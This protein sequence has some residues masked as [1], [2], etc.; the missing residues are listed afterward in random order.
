M[1]LE[2]DTKTESILIRQELFAK[3][4]TFYITTIRPNVYWYFIKENWFDDNVNKKSILL[5][6]IKNNVF[7]VLFK[8]LYYY[9]IF[10]TVMLTVL[11]FM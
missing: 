4:E 10:P 11:C 1:D 3:F 7:L 9:V 8:Y 5:R 2:T 6:K